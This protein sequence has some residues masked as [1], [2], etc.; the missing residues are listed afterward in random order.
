MPVPRPPGPNTS[1]APP[2]RPL[3]APSR[4]TLPTTCRSF[5]CLV[6]STT[7]VPGLEGSASCFFAS[8]LPNLPSSSF[9]LA[10]SS[11]P[12]SFSF[13]TSTFCSGLMRNF[14]TRC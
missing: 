3:K 5:S 11:T 12:A 7:G 1:V 13:F 4:P 2:L 9:A 14:A 10:P 8:C 6:L